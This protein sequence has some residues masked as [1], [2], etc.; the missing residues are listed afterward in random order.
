MLNINQDSRCRILCTK[1]TPMYIETMKSTM[2]RVNGIGFGIHQSYVFF[3]LKTL[4]YY[5]R[6]PCIFRLYNMTFCIN[7]LNEFHWFLST[8]FLLNYLLKKSGVCRYTSKVLLDWWSWPYWP[9]SIREKCRFV[10]KH[11]FYTIHVN[12]C[13]KNEKCKAKA[14]N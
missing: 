13:M 6:D 8:P 9:M 7:I 5:R 2:L 12:K 4:Q 3:T 10:D 14:H 11:F 1:Y